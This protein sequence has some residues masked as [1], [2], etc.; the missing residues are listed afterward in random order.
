M[1]KR[2]KSAPISIYVAPE[3][4]DAAEKTA[5]ADSRSLTSLVEKLLT[6]AA[7]KAGFWPPKG[8]SRR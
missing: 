8:K 7:T 4:K 1:A 2:I 5:K 6:D 3:L